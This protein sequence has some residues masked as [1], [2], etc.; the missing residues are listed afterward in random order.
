VGRK[1]HVFVGPAEREM[2]MERWRDGKG[3]TELVAERG[4]HRI[5]DN[6]CIRGKHRYQVGTGKSWSAI[7]RKLLR[8][9]T[10]KY[11]CMRPW[12]TGPPATSN[13]TPPGETGVASPPV[14]HNRKIWLRFVEP[15]IDSNRC[16]LGAKILKSAQNCTIDARL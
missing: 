2:A 16:A 9:T 4:V 6:E 1:E 10:A 8:K 15:K 11:G 7:A 3:V 14:L 13:R 12:A 5:T